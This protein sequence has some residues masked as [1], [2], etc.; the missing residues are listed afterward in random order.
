MYWYVCIY[1]QPNVSVPMNSCEMNC[2]LDLSGLNS[3]DVD[4]YLV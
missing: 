3:V 4:E 2:V 1:S